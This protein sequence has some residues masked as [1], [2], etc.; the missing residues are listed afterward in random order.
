MR[1][2]QGIDELQLVLR[3]DSAWRIPAHHQ[4]SGVPAPLQACLDVKRNEIIFGFVERVGS[5]F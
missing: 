2:G 1:L 4:A 5:Y 3:V